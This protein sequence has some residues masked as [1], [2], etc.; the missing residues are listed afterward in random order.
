MVAYPWNMQV[1]RLGVKL[2]LQLLVYVI[3]TAL[4]DPSCVCNLLHNSLKCWIL[5]LL[6]EA[7]ERSCVFMDA[8]QIHFH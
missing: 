8:S 3:A 5:N 1:P 4:P 6:S 7:R 2:Q